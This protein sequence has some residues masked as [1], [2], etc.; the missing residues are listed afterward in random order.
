MKKVIP[1]LKDPDNV[2][3]VNDTTFLHDRAPCMKALATQ[4]LPRNNQVDFFGNNEWPGNS[5]DLNA[6]E[7][8][9][10]IVKDRVEKRM[11]SSRDSLDDTLMRI[12]GDMELDTELF[13]ALLESYPARLEAVRKAG[14]VISKY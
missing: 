14:G 13:S 4:A 11:F 7:N 1:F 5:P 6:C 8:L 12:L 3:S 9:G 2:I 10:A